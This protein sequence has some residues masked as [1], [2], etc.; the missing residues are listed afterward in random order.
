[1]RGWRGRAKAGEGQEL[2]DTSIS[3][4]SEVECPGAQTQIGQLRGRGGS[5]DSENWFRKNEVL[6]LIRIKMGLRL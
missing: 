2:R 6:E 3:G 4:A 5:W 1:M